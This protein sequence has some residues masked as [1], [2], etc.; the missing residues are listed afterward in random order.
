MSKWAGR[1]PPRFCDGSETI[2]ILLGMR[3]LWMQVSHYRTAEWCSAQPHINTNRFNVFTCTFWMIKPGSIRSHSRFNTVKISGDAGWFG[4]H[5]CDQ[6]ASFD[7]NYKWEKVKDRTRECVYDW[8]WVY[9]S[10]HVVLREAICVCLKC[11]C[12]SMCIRL[13]QTGDKW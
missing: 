2:L 8:L 7:M 6:R 11:L 4:K 9:S 10:V 5:Q 3:M 13:D 1:D 12:V